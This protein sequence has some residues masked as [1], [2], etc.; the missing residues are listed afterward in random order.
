MSTGIGLKSQGGV[1]KNAKGANEAYVARGTSNMPLSKQ[2]SMQ[3]NGNKR[4]AV[5]SNLTMGGHVMGTRHGGEGFGGKAGPSKRQSV[6]WTGG[7]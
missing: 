6:L 4:S 2:K 5:G 3:T 7:K 1:A